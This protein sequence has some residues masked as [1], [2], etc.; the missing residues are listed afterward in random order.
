[1]FYIKVWETKVKN[2]P[3][4][5]DFQAKK[6]MHVFISAKLRYFCINIL[7]QARHLKK[8]TTILPVSERLMPHA[9]YYIDGKKLTWAVTI[10]RGLRNGPTA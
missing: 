1:M 7:I 3:F 4:K 2:N 9:C 8:K 10:G 5:A 6:K